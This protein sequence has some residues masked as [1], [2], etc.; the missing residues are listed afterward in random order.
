MEVL[1]RQKQQRP[2]QCQPE[3]K[4]GCPEPDQQW[5]S[6]GG[7]RLLDS[8]RKDRLCVCVKPWMLSLV[9]MGEVG[10]KGGTGFRK[11]EEETQN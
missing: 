1:E 6:R 5:G 10:G 3:G 8:F 7:D 9:C 2:Q 11:R 4:A